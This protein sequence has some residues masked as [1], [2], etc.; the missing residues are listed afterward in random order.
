[1]ANFAEYCGLEDSTGDLD[2]EFTLSQ[3]EYWTNQAVVDKLGNLLVSSEQE[4]PGQLT[5]Y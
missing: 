4:I 2:R 5:L 1:M 3:L